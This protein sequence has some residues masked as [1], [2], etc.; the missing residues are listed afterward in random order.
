MIKFTIKGSL[1]GLNEYIAASRSNRY[2]S[3]KI[4]KEQQKIITIYIKKAKLEKINYPVKIKTY[5][6]EK[7][8]RRD[9]D[10]ITF[11]Q[12]FINDA[13]VEN[14]ILK[15]DGRKCVKAINHRVSTDKENPRIEVEIY[16][17]NEDE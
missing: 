16:K 15:D 2:L 17:E 13:L 4:K 3:A 1:I 8:N 7:D 14:G 6:I 11:A 5:W 10:N 12:K 9:I